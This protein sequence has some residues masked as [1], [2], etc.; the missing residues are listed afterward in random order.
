MS[1]DKRQSV[2]NNHTFKYEETVQ[3]MSK[4][5]VTVCLMSYHVLMASWAKCLEKSSYLCYKECWIKCISIC[6]FCPQN[7]TQS[8]DFFREKSQGWDDSIYPHIL[9]SNHYT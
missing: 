9:C 3:I 6:K 5:K 1:Q 4:K 2:A 8:T 7:K